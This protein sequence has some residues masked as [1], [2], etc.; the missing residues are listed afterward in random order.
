MKLRIGLSIILV[1]IVGIIIVLIVR[2]SKKE[3]PIV[4]PRTPFEDTQPLSAKPQFV[5]QSEQQEYHEPDLPS[6]SKSINSPLGT[7]SA[8]IEP[9]EWEEVGNLFVRYNKTGTINQLTHYA[10]TRS[11]TPKALTWFDDTLLLVI[12]G[13]TWGTCTV[14]G[15]LFLVNIRDGRFYDIFRPPVRQEVAEVSKQNNNI[16]LRIASWD[17]DYMEYDLS[18]KVMSADSVILSIAE[19]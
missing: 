8:Y 14:G 17:D 15:S 6:R 9:F 19:K 11:S 1:I 4:T 16:I 2:N 3:Q 12:E 10:P 5:P 18:T 7:Y 13:Y